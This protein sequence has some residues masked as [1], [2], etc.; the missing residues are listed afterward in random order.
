MKKET[1]L[2][3]AIILGIEINK[4]QI[5]INLLKYY[6]DMLIK[7]LTFQEKYEYKQKI[8]LNASELERIKRKTDNMIKKIE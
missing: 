1:A 7:Q 8:I 5:E 2:N 4:L 3:K 6:Q